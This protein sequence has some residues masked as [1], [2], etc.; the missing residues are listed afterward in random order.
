MIANWHSSQ[1]IGDGDFSTPAL[2]AYDNLPMAAYGGSS[3]L[4]SGNEGPWQFS[5]GS[6]GIVADNSQ[7]TGETPSGVGGSGWGNPNAPIG[8][9]A[10]F[11]QAYGSISQSLYLSPGVYSLQF[12]AAQRTNT[13]TKWQTLQVSVDGHP[14][15]T[16][17]PDLSI[18]LRSPS[19]TVYGVRNDQYQLFTTEFTVSE[20]GDHAIEL[21]GLDPYGGDN[22]AFVDGVD[23]FLYSEPEGNPLNAN[24]IEYFQA[25]PRHQAAT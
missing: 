18:L 16:D 9:Q 11:I 24:R 6:A 25:P 7:H 3:Y 22:T 23:V 1:N 8:N 12:W 2:P 15:G 10:A 20:S 19:R 13:N 17:S 14:Q 21:A 4:N 5:P